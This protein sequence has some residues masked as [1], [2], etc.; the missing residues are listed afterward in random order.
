[1]WR[2]TWMLLVRTVLFVTWSRWGSDLFEN[3]K[4]V[5]LAV[6]VLNSSLIKSEV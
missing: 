4:P 6:Y 1:M 3:W 5:S 2:R